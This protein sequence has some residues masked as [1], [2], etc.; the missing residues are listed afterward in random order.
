[1]LES[2][3]FRGLQPLKFFGFGLCFSL[4]NVGKTQTQRILKGGEGGRKTNLGV[5]FLW[6]FFCRSLWNS[7]KSH[8]KSSL[9]CIQLFSVFMALPRIFIPLLWKCPKGTLRKDSVK[10]SWF[11]LELSWIPWNSARIYKNFTGSALEIYLK[12]SYPPGAVWE[13]V[14]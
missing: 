6:V 7:Q 11:L 2:T 3:F 10:I 12:L 8:Q 5:G 14:L 4:K 9:R 1:M 13:G